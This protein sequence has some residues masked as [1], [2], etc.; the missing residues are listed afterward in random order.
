MALRL[1]NQWTQPAADEY[2]DAVAALFRTFS[3][4]IVERCVDPAQGIARTKV[5]GEPRRWRPSIGEIAAHCDGTVHSDY[6][7]RPPMLPLEPPPPPPTEK[8]RAY[9][10]AKTKEIIARLV[11]SMGGKSPEDQRTEAQQILDRCEREA[12]QAAIAAVQARR[13]PPSDGAHAGR[14]LADLEARRASQDDSPL[15]ELI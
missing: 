4:D 11:R 1:I 8:E 13:S 9:V 10:K 12:K 7:P 2:F 15:D 3:M 6:R 14:A 5:D